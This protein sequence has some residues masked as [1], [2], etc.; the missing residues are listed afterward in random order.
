MAMLLVVGCA[1]LHLATLNDDGR[2]AL[3]SKMMEVRAL[4]ACGAPNF[5]CVH[6][7]SVVGELIGCSHGIHSFISFTARAPQ[8]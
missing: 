1:A 3:P 2:V 5:T 4:G 6:T 7:E 8:T